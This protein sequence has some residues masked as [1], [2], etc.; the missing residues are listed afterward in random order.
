MGISFVSQIA[1]IAL[2]ITS[3]KVGGIC[4]AHLGVYIVDCH[5][6]I[7]ST[8]NYLG[9]AGRTKPSAKTVLLYSNRRRQL[10]QGS[11][12]LIQVGS[13]SKG[14]SSETLK[15]IDLLRSFDGA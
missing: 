3:S 2:D 7:F 12:L 6:W 4:L 14:D 8:K 11:T 10:Y 13:E 1:V 5:G 9:H 15:L